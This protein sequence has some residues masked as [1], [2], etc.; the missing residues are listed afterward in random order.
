ALERVLRR[1]GDEVT[2]LGTAGTSI[3]F[4]NRATGESVPLLL[5]RRPPQ[6]ARPDEPTELVIELDGDQA[7]RFVAGGLPMAEAVL[8]GVVDPILRGLLLQQADD[9][10]KPAPERPAFPEPVDPALLAVELRE[11]WR[12]FGGAPTLRGVDLRIPE[13]VISVILGPP[14][15]GK[16]VVLQHI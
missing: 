10:P 3:T 13:G 12:G 14:G 1:S 5:D 6:L 15:V 4:V 9:A 11:V 8:S 16:S 2:R 7:R